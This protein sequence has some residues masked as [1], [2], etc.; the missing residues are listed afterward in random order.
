MQHTTQGYENGNGEPVLP[1]PEVRAGLD[2]TY[3]ISGVGWEKYR[4][5]NTITPCTAECWAR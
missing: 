2:L 3:E 5:F 4:D 1:E